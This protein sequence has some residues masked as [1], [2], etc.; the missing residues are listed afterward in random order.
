MVVLC[1]LILMNCPNCGARF[2]EIKL[3]NISVDH[4]SV[5][6][7]T[8]F[9]ENEI[10]RISLS[11]A[12]VLSENK[13]NESISGTEKLCPKDKTSMIAF[14]APSI[15]QYVTILKC[16]KCAGLLAFADDL[17]NLKKAQKAKIKY[18]TTWQK[19]LPALKTVLVISFIFV[20]SLSIIYTITPFFQTPTSTSIKATQEIC[21]L[22]VIL[23]GN[24]IFIY[25]KSPYA[26]R[27][28]AHFYNSRTKETIVRN[29][30]TEPKD[31]HLLSVPYDDIAP[32]SDICVSIVLSSDRGAVQTECKTLN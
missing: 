30:N 18:Y 15:P 11:E 12:N 4:C 17:V 22:D 23:S 24:T 27:S 9:D 2:T 19:P 1:I 32:S 26:Y 29:I 31:I 3:K 10:N 8:F 28:Q 16:K 7:I 6:G 14:I 25:C 20:V 5:C 13:T 21:P